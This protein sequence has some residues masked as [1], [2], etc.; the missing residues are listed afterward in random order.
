[1][2]VVRS[3]RTGRPWR[4]Q[5]ADLRVDDHD[6]PV[7]ELQRLVETSARYHRVVRGFE[8]AIDGDPAGGIVQLDGLAESDFVDPDLAM[9]RA[10]VLALAGRHDDAAAGFARLAAET[11]QFLETARRM[12]PAGLF[13][14]PDAVIR[15]VEQAASS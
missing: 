14:D 11:P 9:W 15:A 3:V 10:I 8:T 12:A 6:D 1:V 13:A 7:G 5:L 2:M 4:D